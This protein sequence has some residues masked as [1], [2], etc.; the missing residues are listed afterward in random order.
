MHRGLRTRDAL[1]PGIRRRF[2]PAGGRTRPPKL[3]VEL[4]ESR[5]LPSAC[6]DMALMFGSAAFFAQAG[7]TSIGWLNA[8]YQDVY[9]RQP[10]AVELAA[11]QQALANGDTRTC[12]AAQILGCTAADMQALGCGTGMPQGLQITGLL[13]PAVA[14]ACFPLANVPVATFIDGR[15]G[16]TPADFTAN[17]T[18]G[19]G[20]IS[21]ASAAAGTITESAPGHFTV[22]G[23]HTYMTA[24]AIIT[25]GLSVQVTAVNGEYDTKAEPLLVSNPDVKLTLKSVDATGAPTGVIAGAQWA[26]PYA[27]DATV[28]NPTAN[29]VTVQISWQ[30]EYGS[31][32]P[33]EPARQATVSAQL[34][35][36]QTQVVRLG[37]LRHTWDWIHQEDP[38]GIVSDI[39]TR[40][41]AA[42]LAAL[43]H[44]IAPQT[45]L[46]GLEGLI[47]IKDARLSLNSGPTVSYSATVNAS[48]MPS[49][50]AP[51]APV[52]IALDGGI[53]PSKKAWFTDYL[54][55]SI[56]ASVATDFGFLLLLPNPPAAVAFFTAA[57]FYTLSA[58]L[59][60]K[61][62]FDPPDP[63][64]TQVASPPTIT[65]PEI[66]SI[67]PGPWRQYAE[68]ARD[69]YSVDVAET[70]SLDRAQAALAAGSSDWETT[71]LLAAAHYGAGAASLESQLA[72]IQATLEP[73]I[74]SS[75]TFNG[76]AITAA[77]KTTGLPD[78][79]VHYL[80]EFGWTPTQIDALRQNLVQLDP[81]LLSD[82]SLPVAA[83]QVTADAAATDARDSLAAGGYTLPQRFVAQLYEDLLGR[84]VDPQGVVSWTSLLNGG[85]SRSQV[86]LAITTTSEY[87]TD[88]VN[89][90]YV[91]LLHRPA[92]PTGL[93]SFV[94]F[95]QGGGTFE[96][97]QAA[98]VGSS[99][100]YQQ[101][102]GGN[103]DGFLDAL[104]GDLL[105]RGVDAIGR[106]AWDQ[107]MQSGT[108][109]GQVATRIL[110]SNE[111]RQDLVTGYYEQVLHRAPDTTGLG[112]WVN[113]LQ[114][115][116]RDQD[117]VAGIL[118]SEEYFSFRQP[119]VSQIYNDVLGRPVD[120]AG[121]ASW[122]SV[123][124]GGASAA[125]VASLIETTPE[126]RMNEVT[127]LYL[128]YL[129]RTPDDAGLNHFVTLLQNGARL[130]QVAAAIV[131][132]AEYFADRGG[133]SNDGFLGALYEDALGRAIDPSGLASW[134]QALTNGTTPGQVAAVIL[135]SDE[136]RQDLIQSF[137]RRFLRRDADS[138]GLNAFDNA[139]Q[140]GARDQDIVAAMVG[141][142]EYFGRL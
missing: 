33:R 108:T 81:Q 70:T 129:H 123:L 69:L 65:V 51:V 109:P 90:L 23:T 32:S 107:A 78:V 91:S 8:V 142:G 74:A 55:N 37:T 13:T 66:E 127:N 126:Y 61:E 40:N 83:L 27:L 79:E 130:E 116:G 12:V 89:G 25:P 31:D 95:L 75:T 28:T 111:Y 45:V 35:P 10:S 73:L 87:V 21:E 128:L 47:D 48:A 4:L 5:T 19:D 84:A 133:A 30:E 64:F 114:G 140:H 137:Y 82:P 46:L 139:L 105:G 39:F 22:S 34:G 57:T 9:N 6:T 41:A 85:N 115:G 50:A 54:L 20:F 122:A 93:S 136:F 67:P 77:L 63:L 124:D 11:G 36:K 121:L 134:N 135:G 94:G 141:S 99:E 131:G 125:Q 16:A 24:G 92:D 43:A 71:Q 97:V 80:T 29:A 96:Q 103:N 7:A 98:L 49:C 119:L 76:P 14:T 86:A 117:V 59:A 38:A 132:S 42:A 102:G 52:T 1:G 60:Y 18:W 88:R 120:A 110:A 68:A 101:R 2:H 3:Q 100:Y 138:A 58:N 56:V 72:T 15:P 106:S 26:Q 104:Y 53:S 44:G 62:A 113:V 118:G 112:A 17:I